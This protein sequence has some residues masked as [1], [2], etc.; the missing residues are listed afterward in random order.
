MR[1]KDFNT[2]PDQEALALV[3]ACADV[4]RWAQ[5]VVAHRPY[6]SVESAVEA[7]M[8][9]ADPWT[10]DE[11]DAA[12]DRHPRIGERAG[13]NDADAQHSRKEQAGLSTEETVQRRLAEGNA[14]YEAKFGH[15]FL[16]RAAG[17]SA[18]EILDQLNQRLG[19]TPAEERRIAAE[20]LREI[21]AVRL[22]GE[23]I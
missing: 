18:E 15:V 4:R 8:S 16:I 12:L 14:E 10:D 22:R 5:E 21:A 23:L 13:G 2:A 3:L 1:L 6:D 17:R 9:V 7:A 19:H 11:V 20:Q